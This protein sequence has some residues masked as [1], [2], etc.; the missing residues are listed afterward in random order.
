[1]TASLEAGSVFVSNGSEVVGTVALWLVGAFEPCYFLGADLANEPGAVE[2]RVAG[3][4]LI[5]GLALFV[6][7]AFLEP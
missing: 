2:E 7:L 6:D 5:T 3:L 4:V 1:M